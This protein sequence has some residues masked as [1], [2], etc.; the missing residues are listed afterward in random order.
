MKI[1]K[2]E[3]IE[4]EDIK[5][6]V[7]SKVFFNPSIGIKVERDTLLDI[8]KIEL[9]TDFTRIDFI[10]QAPDKYINGGWIEMDPNSFIRPASSSTIYKM[11]KAINISIAPIKTYFKKSGQIHVFTLIFPPLP[12]DVTVIDIIE[13]EGLGTYFNFYN[14][15]LEKNATTI[16]HVN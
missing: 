8:Y 7:P 12:S 10:Y 2:V 14:V 15:Q 6:E 16:I 11:V 5:V 3:I 9:N 13:K 1:E 4:I